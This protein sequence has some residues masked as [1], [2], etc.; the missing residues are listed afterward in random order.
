MSLFLLTLTAPLGADLD[1]WT[2]DWSWLLGSCLQ[3]S[4]VGRW[5]TEPWQIENRNMK[6]KTWKKQANESQEL[7]NMLKLRIVGFQFG[8]CRK[9]IEI[10][11][12]I[13]MENSRDDAAEAED[14]SNPGS[15]RGWRT[16]WMLLLCRC[17]N[18]TWRH[19]TV[20]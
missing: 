10:D 11:P 20:T 12:L 15:Q 13:L 5:T 7:L 8:K 18:W 3:G 19:L 14:W 2:I 1:P 16:G 17:R 9:R 4:G 6:E